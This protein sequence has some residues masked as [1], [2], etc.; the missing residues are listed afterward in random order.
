MALVI[1]DDV[2][3]SAHLSADELKRE[4]AILL[5]QQERLTLAQASSLIGVSRLQFQQLLA[6]RNITIHYD[7]DDFAQDIQTMHQLGDL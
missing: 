2:L 7:D 1:P 3:Q 6:Q 4:V 5:F